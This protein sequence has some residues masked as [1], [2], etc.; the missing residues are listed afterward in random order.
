[1]NINITANERSWTSLSRQVM[2]ALQ[3]EI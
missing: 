3:N 1:M 2:N